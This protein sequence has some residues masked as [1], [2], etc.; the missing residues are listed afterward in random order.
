MDTIEPLLYI[1]D[2]F[3]M[4]PAQQHLSEEFRLYHN[5]YH[6]ISSNSYIH[7]DTR[8]NETIVVEMSDNEVRVLTR[9]LRQYIAARQMALAVFFESVVYSDLSY[10]AAYA[11]F[12]SISLLNDEI[13]YSFNIG[14]ASSGALSRLL[15]K[16]IIRPP[17]IAKCGVWPYETKDER[18]EIFIIGTDDQGDPITHSCDESGL[19]NYFGANENSPHYLTPVWFTK[20]VLLKYYNNSEKYSVEDGY[21][22]CGSLWGL[23]MDN[24]LPEH[25]AVYLGDL[26]SDLDYSEQVYWR[27][28][29]V[30]PIS[31]NTSN[32]NFARSFAAQFSDPTASDLLFKQK[33]AAFSEKW[34][35]RFGWPIFRPPHQA[36]LHIFKQCC[37]PLT[38]NQGEF[39]NQILFLVKMIVDSL[40]DAAL[41]AA[42]GGPLPEEKSISKLKRW[43]EVNAY[44][45]TDRDI[46]TVRTLQDLRSSGA[47]HAKGSRFEKI[48][49]RLG[50]DK[51]S[52][53]EVFRQ[54]LFYVITMLDGLE[55]FF[56][57]PAT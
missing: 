55:R 31:A 7:I 14:H 25:V 52:R 56:L 8:G 48:R 54:L 51:N 12:P 45:D 43:L 46:E 10:E 21:L 47:A 11:K 50:L 18:H 24:H 23:Q 53:Q 9:F 26:G 13:C 20:D 6:D 44:P 30:S 22:R 3:G 36:D 37:V 2:F 1:Q 28:F 15:G 39:D 27:H 49:M 16:K 4:K 41:V 57:T 5:L 38:D 42:L 19:A 32:T 35:K 40:N 17:E 34:E 29:N 33:Y